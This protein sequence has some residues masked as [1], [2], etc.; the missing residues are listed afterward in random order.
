M[1]QRSFVGI[2]ADQTTGTTKAID[3]AWGGGPDYL[4]KRLLDWYGDDVVKI[5]SL[6]GGGS[7]LQLQFGPGKGLPTGG[8]TRVYDSPLAYLR[9]AAFAFGYYGVDYLYLYDGG[10]KYCPAWE[11]SSSGWKPLERRERDAS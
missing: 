11:A 6:I 9:N 10:W 5:N 3:V 2:V 8:R 7:I 1:N 4:G